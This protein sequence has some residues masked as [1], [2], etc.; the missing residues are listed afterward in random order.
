MP[1]KI[2]IV[3]DDMELAEELAEILR[4]EGYF[5]ENTS[6]SLQAGNLINKNTY[7][8]YLLDYKMS[9]FSGV[10]LLKKIKENTLESAVFI[11]SGRPSIDRLL[12][13]ENVYHLVSAVIKKP[14]DVE[15]LLR[16]IKVFT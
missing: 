3:D 6:D 2:L 11:I 5:V 12:K 13:E 9:S 16:K 14:F 4:D 1:K 7:D 15:A 8:L 10:D